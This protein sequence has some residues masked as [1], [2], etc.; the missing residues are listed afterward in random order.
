MARPLKLTPPITKKIH[1]KQVD[2]QPKRV[3]L[4]ALQKSNMS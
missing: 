3:N 1:I 2:K 4:P